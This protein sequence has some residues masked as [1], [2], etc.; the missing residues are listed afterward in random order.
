MADRA[1]QIAQARQA[2]YSDAQIIE[3]LSATDPQVK[4]AVGAGYKP[5]EIVGH[6]TA[7]PA[8]TAP[9]TPSR[10][11]AQADAKRAQDRADKNRVA[12]GNPKNAGRARAAADSY[13]FGWVD[14]L[15]GAGA[16]LKTGA[17][18]ALGMGPGY[19]A[20]EAYD[21]TT[22]EYRSRLQDTRKNDA[23]GYWVNQGIGAV[24]NPT[25][26]IGG[27]AIG[28][29]RTGLGQV[30]R[31]ALVGAGTGAAAGAGSGTDLQSRTQNAMVG[32]GI[33]AATGATFQAGSNALAARGAQVAARPPSPQRVLSQRGVQLTP[34]QMMG[35][36]AQ[37]IEDGFQSVP[38][39]GDFIRGA[40]VRGIES[41]DR[42]AINQTLAPIG[43]T[44]PPG[45][46]VGRDGVRLARERISAA[47]T[48]ALD[49]V[50]V[51]PDQP[52]AAEL[53]RARGVQIAGGAGDELGAAVD[54]IEQ[55]MAGGPISGRVLKELDEEI[56]IAIR[57]TA[58]TP[59][60]RALVRELHALQDALDGLLGRVDPNALAAK[61][62]ADEAWA[63]LVRIESAAGMVGSR[64]GVFGPSQLNSTVRSAEG[65][66]RRSARYA[67]GD[68]L[69]QDL[70]DPAMA[71]LPQTVPDSGTA[72]RT[73]ATAGGLTAGGATVGV[74]ALPLAIAGGVAAATG[75]VY[76]RP[77]IAAINAVYRATTPGAA[78]QA[79]AE[80]ARLAA[81]EPALFPV[82]QELAG[83]RGGQSAPQ[84]ISPAPLQ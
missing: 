82:Y 19:S 6:L 33:G 61:T 42:V 47:Y 18:N 66:G 80:L 52:F 77:A 35:G 23:A 40:K 54:R 63:N 27:A 53:A 79:L 60:G 2:G 58:G 69:M 78:E 56:G 41:F 21:A 12:G 62:A 76:S 10:S 1:Q 31:A 74:D 72:F 17:M 45:T 28:G 37:R 75:A 46:A 59:T 84:P 73:L 68:A 51:A 16:A 34:G 70:S 43:E 5:E 81:R 8:R 30:G 15:A 65:G 7:K 50:Q 36:A 25:N 44:L 39:A 22:Q 26:V 49:P 29:A 83:L 13:S 57:S 67:R 38:V 11:R 55:A 64:G 20:G 48:S 24:A 3:H 14:E 32:A 9:A 71:V 4:Q